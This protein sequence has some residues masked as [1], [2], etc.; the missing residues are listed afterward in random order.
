MPGTAAGNAMGRAAGIAG[1]SHTRITLALDIVRRLTDGPLAGFHELGIVKKKIDL[2]DVIEVREAPRM[3]IV[4][5]HPEVPSD[6]SNLCWRAAEAVRAACGVK[7]AVRIEIEK[8]IPVRGGLA[9]G[10]ANAATVMVLLDELW[11]LGLDTQ[12][13]C[14]LGRGV[15]MDVP[16][17]FVGDTAF[18]TETV[19]WPERVETALTFDLV[20][21]FPAFG[22][23]TRDAYGRIDYRVTG[24]RT[25]DTTAM[26]NALRANDRETVI[27][28]MHNDFEYSVLDA[29]P[30]LAALRAE[31]LD[32]GCRGVVMSG[33]GSTLVGI[34]DSA[35]EARAC[36][37]KLSTRCLVASTRVAPGCGTTPAVS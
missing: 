11:G 5:E 4:C 33:S 22:V 20:L 36:A 37:S 16:F 14:E 8:R 12:R 2:H 10:S 13:L 17:Y 29:H 24:R 31:M 23:S 1:R 21:A 18:D 35:R 6:A 28:L 27:A 34:A 30:L 3:E 19:G 9:G 32:A 15:G 7:Q 25:G 26:L